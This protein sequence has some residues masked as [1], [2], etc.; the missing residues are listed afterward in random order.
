MNE[1]PG[2]GRFMAWI[3]YSSRIVLTWLIKTLCLLAKI[4]R[5]TNRVYPGM[6]EGVQL[7]EEGERA[8]ENPEH[9]QMSDGQ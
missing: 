3:Y 6:G 1:S 4:G 8:G 9:A 2:T 5:E 7:P